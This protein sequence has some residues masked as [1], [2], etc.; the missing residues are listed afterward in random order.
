[1][2]QAGPGDWQ[3]GQSQR[4][5]ETRGTGCEGRGR[6]TELTNGAS[7]EATKGKETDNPLESPEGTAYW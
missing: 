7:L 6:A 4:E 5:A 1:M 2:I 3:E